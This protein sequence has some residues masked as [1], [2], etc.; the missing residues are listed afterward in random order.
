MLFVEI[1]YDVNP[2]DD[3]LPNGHENWQPRE[4]PVY[5]DEVFDYTVL[6]QPEGKMTRYYD[7]CSLGNLRVLG[8]Y[9][10]KTITVKE[11]EVGRMNLT[12][13]KRAVSEQLRP[14]HLPQETAQPWPHS[15][16]GKMPPEWAWRK[17][18]NPTMNFL[19]TT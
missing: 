13:I 1:D 16:N 3:P 14:V 15:I 4:L 7:F 11:S 6:P 10:H 19:L 8:D 9:F 5:A 2:Q 17:S 18:T 12:S